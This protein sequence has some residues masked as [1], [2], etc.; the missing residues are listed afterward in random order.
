MLIRHFVLSGV[1][2]MLEEKHEVKYVLHTDSTSRK[3]G[4][5]TNVEALG[6]KNTVRFNVPRKRMG[7]WDMLYCP[8]VLH[9]QRGTPNYEGR[10]ELMYCLR[11]PKWVRR[12]EFLSKPLIFPIYR[13]LYSKAMGVYKELYKFIHDEA[14]DVVLHPSILQGYFINELVPICSRLKV[15]FVC[16]MNSWDNPSQKAAAT[17][18]ADKLVVW[19][20]TITQTCRRING[21]AS[22]RRF[23][24]R[25]RS[26]SN[27]SKTSSR[28]Q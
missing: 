3:K 12:Y 18:V 21:Y 6:L 27:L 13:F 24:I 5:Y 25:R 22:G 8:T 1:F 16:L 26:I 28:V 14:P 11:D 4:I 7:R 23:N 20:R 9:N 17:G 2:K 19:G 15:P 10:L